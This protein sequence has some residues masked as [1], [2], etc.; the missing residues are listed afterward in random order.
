MHV[1][2]YTAQWIAYSFSK[3]TKLYKKIYIIIFIYYSRF[4]FLVIENNHTWTPF[5]HLS[6]CF[7]RKNTFQHSKSCKW[8]QEKRFHFFVVLKKNLTFFLSHCLVNVARNK[9]T[10]QS[11]PYLA[12][13]SLFDSSNAVDGLKSDL[14]AW[15]GQCAVSADGF[16]TATWWVNLTTVHPPGG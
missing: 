16:K 6:F 1:L 7:V 5:R 9:W 14:T 13:V 8:F 3:R 15:G 10:W 12:G 4:V 11:T 2:Y